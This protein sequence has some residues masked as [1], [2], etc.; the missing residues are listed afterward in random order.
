MGNIFLK[1]LN[2]VILIKK[3][4]ETIGWEEVLWRDVE[5]KSWNNLLKL[6]TKKSEKNM[7]DDLIFFFF[8]ID[9]VL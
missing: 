2:P 5:K 6:F 4:L 8:F 3:H 9:K 7:Y 1:F